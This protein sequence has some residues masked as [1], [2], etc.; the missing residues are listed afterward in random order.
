MNNQRANTS[1]DPLLVPDINIPSGN[2]SA[3]ASACSRENLVFLAT[4]LAFYLAQGLT[5]VELETLVNLI[6]ITSETLDAILAQR[7]IDSN[8]NDVTPTI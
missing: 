3:S 7:V 5:K 8:A 4:T 6:N 2:A 1:Q